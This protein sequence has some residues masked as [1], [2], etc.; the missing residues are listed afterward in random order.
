MCAPFAWKAHALRSM[1]P[2]KCGPAVLV[3]PCQVCNG[4]Q[5]VCKGQDEHL[6]QALACCSP[7][8]RQQLWRRSP[9]LRVVAAAAVHRRLS[10]R[11]LTATVYKCNDGTIQHSCAE[12][13]FAL[14]GN[15]LFALNAAPPNQGVKAKLAM[16][17]CDCSFVVCYTCVGSAI[18]A[19]GAR[20][21]CYCWSQS[22]CTQYHSIRAS[23]IAPPS[24]QLLYSYMAE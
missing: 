5:R 17:V 14:S 21:S 22:S 16:H 19:D 12:G 23:F 4:R 11:Y 13:A 8:R 18:L 2:F 6:R 7:R 9:A 3:C 10:L 20:C 24:A 15:G 1:C